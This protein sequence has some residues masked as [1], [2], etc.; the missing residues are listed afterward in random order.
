MWCC[1]CL[2]LW[3][4]S[5]RCWFLAS[6][7]LLRSRLWVMSSLMTSEGSGTACSSTTPS[8]NWEREKSTLIMERSFLSW[9]LLR[10]ASQISPSISFYPKF[11]V[12]SSASQRCC[13][14]YGNG[15]NGNRAQRW[16][17]ISH[18]AVW[19]MWHPIHF[20]TTFKFVCSGGIVL[21]HTMTQ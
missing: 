18:N 14:C 3:F 17:H 9:H 11:W 10:R 6:R 5:S 16:S 15:N 2:S 21:Y 20:Q 12:L 8:L 13:C 19:M 1:S 4:S 7:C